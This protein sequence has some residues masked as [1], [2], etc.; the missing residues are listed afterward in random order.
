[1]QPDERDDIVFHGTLCSSSFEKVEAGEMSSEPKHAHAP[2]VQVLH[3][4]YVINGIRHVVPLVHGLRAAP[5]GFQISSGRGSA[6]SSAASPSSQR[7]A[8][9]LTRRTSLYGGEGKLLE[10]VKEAD[11]R[12]S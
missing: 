5:Y 2:Y 9:P 10:A 1:M 4:F 7:P 12:S 8:P 3:S 11:E 6:A